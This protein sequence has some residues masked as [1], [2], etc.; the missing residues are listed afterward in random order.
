MYQETV[1]SVLKVL[2]FKYVF[3][4]FKTLS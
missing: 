2:Y 1:V 4:T 3:V